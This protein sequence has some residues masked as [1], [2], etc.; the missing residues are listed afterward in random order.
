MIKKTPYNLSFAHLGEGLSV[1]RVQADLLPCK[2]PNDKE[3]IN[4]AVFFDPCTK[5]FNEDANLLEVSL[6]GRKMVGKEMKIN[7]YEAI[8][9]ALDK[10]ELD[11]SLQR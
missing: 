10:D 3:N 4:R 6:Q 11:T 7:G 5:P 1:E 8:V 2:F 9:M